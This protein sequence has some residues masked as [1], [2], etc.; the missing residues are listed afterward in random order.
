M[1]KLIFILVIFSTS[2]YVGFMY[3]ETFK[4]RKEQLN[5]ILK[6]LMILEND[7]LYGNTPLPEALDKLS[8][9]VDEPLSKIIKN[10]AKNLIEGKVEGVYEGFYGEFIELE[11]EFY[12]ID[13]D[14]K[15]LRDFLKSLG[16]SGV[17]GQ[18]KI[19]KLAVE[20]IK[21][22]LREADDIAKKNVKLYR[23]LGVCFGMMISIFLI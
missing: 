12:L 22:N 21:I 10:S 3:A 2:S 8:L 11:S 18:E 9:K 17:Y 23:Y 4:K 14:K 16:E 20:E 7:V 15:V 6:A 19:F 1:F 5:E 13:T